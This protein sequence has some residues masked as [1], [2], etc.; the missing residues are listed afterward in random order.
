MYLMYYFSVVY[1]HYILGYDID[2]K[3]IILYLKHSG[4]GGYFCHFAEICHWHC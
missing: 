1:N 3:G 4:G 2:F